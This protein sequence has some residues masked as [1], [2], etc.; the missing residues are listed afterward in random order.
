MSM[1]KLKVLC[2]LCL[3]V[4]FNRHEERTAFGDILANPHTLV[5]ELNAYCGTAFQIDSM[6]FFTGVD[7]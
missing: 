6:C 3:L 7:L 4:E 2:S 1:L 5:A